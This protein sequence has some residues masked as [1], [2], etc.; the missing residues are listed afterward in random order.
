MRH[1]DS[2]MRVDLFK[3]D[4]MREVL[5]CN[6]AKGSVFRWYRMNNESEWGWQ[7]KAY[8]GWLDCAAPVVFLNL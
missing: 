8:E 4:H 5:A 3:P 6:D 7:W 2:M 1:L